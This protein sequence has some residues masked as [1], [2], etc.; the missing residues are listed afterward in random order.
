MTIPNINSADSIK[1]RNDTH[2]EEQCS[3]ASSPCSICLHLA[4]AR[5]EKLGL[6]SEAVI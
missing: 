6:R 1:L 4:R 3:A 5:D 2:W